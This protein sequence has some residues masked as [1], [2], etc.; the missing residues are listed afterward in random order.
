M[1]RRGEPLFSEVLPPAALKPCIIVLDQVRN[2][3]L[4][5]YIAYEEGLPTTLN[6]DVFSEGQPHVEF[7]RLVAEAAACLRDLPFTPISTSRR[8]AV[9]MNES[10]KVSAPFA[11]LQA[12]S[13][14]TRPALCDFPKKISRMAK[15]SGSPPTSNKRNPDY[16]IETRSSKKAKTAPEPSLPPRTRSSRRNKKPAHPLRTGLRSQSKSTPG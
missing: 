4:D 12:C 1:L 3:L 14:S 13:S 6:P 10:V 8:E 9:T 2:Y 11:P 15:V 5:V 16:P 7:R